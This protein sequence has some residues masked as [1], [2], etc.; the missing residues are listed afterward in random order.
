VAEERR[1]VLF[2]SHNMAAVENLCVRT[3]LVD[4]GRLIS[5][6]ET[7]DTVARYL[8]TVHKS[9]A[10]AGP[11]LAG[12]AEARIAAI[13][14]LDELGDPIPYVRCGDD[15]N[16]ALTIDTFVEIS[17]VVMTVG[18]TSSHDVRVAALNS[19]ISGSTLRLPPGRHTI[20][21]RVRRLPLVPGSYSLDVAL[22]ANAKPIIWAP[23][24]SWL[25]IETA[26]YFGSGRLP[27]VSWAGFALLPQEWRVVG[28][29]Q[30][31]RVDSGA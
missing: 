12:G 7:L 30:K 18:I 13:G 20:V 19:D 9:K 21:C 29:D 31:I 28:K 6:G 24:L 2:V 25:K 1:T 10:S 16:L 3:A 11:L 23:G 8:Q 17:G 27:D 14:P 26:D 4:A 5:Y 22:F 15:L